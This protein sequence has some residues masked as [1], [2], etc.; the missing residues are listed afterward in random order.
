MDKDQTAAMMATQ[1]TDGL[2]E[3]AEN[4]QSRKSA[5]MRGRVLEA[6]V[7]WLVERGYA[8]FSVL[9]LAEKA[10]VSRGALQHHFP[11]KGDLIS[12]VIDHV[13][14][15]R[16]ARFLAD[17]GASATI[18]DDQPQQATAMYWDSVN[19]RDYAAYLELMVASRTDAELRECFE[20]GALRY[21]RA[22]IKEVAGSF[23]QWAGNEHRLQVA[24]DFVAATHLGLL[25]M[26][27][28]PEERRRDVLAFTEDAVVGLYQGRDTRGGGDP[29]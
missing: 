1:E 21:D 28:M 8:G 26:S 5:R 6:A 22:W 17:F 29:A 19:S 13:V 23:P 2:D 18:V 24:S 7:D 12:A 11:T 27:T 15:R 20:Q 10:G 25:L 16:I 3:S 14:D 9:A 4:W